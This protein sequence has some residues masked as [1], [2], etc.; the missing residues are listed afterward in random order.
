MK[1]DDSPLVVPCWHEIGIWGDHSCPELPSHAHCH[2][3]PR[4]IQTGQGLLHRPASADYIAALAK[5]FDQ[6]LQSN[7][8][9]EANAAG[10]ESLVVF[11]LGQEWWA[12]AANLIRETAPASPVHSLPHRS[13]D[14]L[15]GLIGVRGELLLYVSLRA[16]LSLGRETASGEGMTSTE[17]GELL[18]AELESGVWAFSVDELL[19]LQQIPRQRLQLTPA[20]LSKTQTTCTQAIFNWQGQQVN[21]LD[22][23]LLFYRIQ[24]RALDSGAVAGG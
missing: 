3:C 11:R 20:T 10:V 17:P 12:I 14:V 24:R 21:L 15:K 23:E 7:Q 16:L 9:V 6:V 19:G 2:N 13:N 18:V 8:E 22:G 5:Q 1:P 4:Y